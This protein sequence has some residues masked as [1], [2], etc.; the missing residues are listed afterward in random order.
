MSQCRIRALSCVLVLQSHTVGLQDTA[1][2]TE[3]ASCLVPNHF[4]FGSVCTAEDLPCQRPF[5]LVGDILWSDCRLQKSHVPSKILSYNTA[6]AVVRRLSRPTI[7]WPHL[8]MFTGETLVTDKCLYQLMLLSAPGRC[9]W[10]CYKI[11]C[12]AW[13]LVHRLTLT[14]ITVIKLS[15]Q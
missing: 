11:V 12:P 4:D 15:K 8:C 14:L 13:L 2:T 10:A 3:W 9:C 1:V 6:L 7:C 5:L